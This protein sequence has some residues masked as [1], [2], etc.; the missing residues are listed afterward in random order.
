MCQKEEK[1]L[2]Q[3]GEAD[4][5]RQYRY[6]RGKIVRQ[7]IGKYFYEGKDLGLYCNRIGATY[8]G[9]YIHF[10]FTVQV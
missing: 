9:S 8:Y 5:I 4:R 2:E 10:R 7:I 1:L 6:D 3:L